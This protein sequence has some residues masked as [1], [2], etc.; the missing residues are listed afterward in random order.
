MKTKTIIKISAIISA[1]LLVTACSFG[2]NTDTQSQAIIETTIPDDPVVNQIQAALSERGVAFGMT[3]DEVI[4]AETV[5]FEVDTNKYKTNEELGLKAIKS[6]STVKYMGYNATLGYEFDE[7]KLKK[8]TYE[9][10]VEFG[11]K[12]IP[13]S[14]TYNLYSKIK[15]QFIDVIGEPEPHDV[16]DAVSHSIGSD[17]YFDS[18]RYD[19]NYS[20]IMQADQTTSNIGFSETFIYENSVLI[21]FSRIYWQLER[22]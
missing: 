6:T 2:G 1:A 21:S 12:D 5:K 16:V 7:D 14:L 10:K 9:I 19:N 4:N 18:W 8:M 13:S 17:H 22:K 20:I 15:S 3:E 11:E